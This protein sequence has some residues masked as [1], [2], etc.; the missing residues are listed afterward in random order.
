MVLVFY[1]P[2]SP[3]FLIAN[4][5][6]A[7]ALAFLVKYRESAPCILSLWADRSLSDGNGNPNSALVALEI[8]EMRESISLDGIDKRWW[9]CTLHLTLKFCP[10]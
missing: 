10:Y 2:E 6:E 9:D 8:A 3:R 1:I 7:E 4:G 5:K